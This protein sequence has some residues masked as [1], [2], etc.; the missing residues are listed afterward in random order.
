LLA[1]DL[2]MRLLVIEKKIALKYGVGE[3]PKHFDSSVQ[4]S[5][6]QS[7]ESEVDEETALLRGQQRSQQSVDESDDQDPDYDIA[8]YELPG[9]HSRIIN[10]VP[11]FAC[12]QNP[13]LLVAFLI[14]ISQAALIAAFDAT[15]PLIAIQWYQ[16]SPLKAGLLFLPMSVFDLAVGPVAGWAVDKYG[17]KPAAVLGFLFLTPVYILYR[18]ARPGG[19]HEV[20]VYCVLL[21]FAGAGLSM[22][23]SPSIVESG[24]L[25]ERYHKANPHLFGEAGPYAQLYGISSMCFSLGL[26]IGPI[27]GGSLK[28]SIGYANMNAVLASICV[29]MTVLCFFYIGE[30]WRG[31]VRLRQKR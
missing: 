12:L 5:T 6:E 20:A 31:L 27:I 8:D 30:D 18:V 25:M 13:S 9:P 2:V 16:L 23:N 3:A 4:S 11:I 17:T 26:T 24:K 21:G 10:A 7:H 19:A 1:V 15:V 22:A 14:S 29:L 28:E